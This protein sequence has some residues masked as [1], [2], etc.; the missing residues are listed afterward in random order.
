M[1]VPEQRRLAGALVLVG[2][3]AAC[4]EPPTR[5]LAMAQGAIDAARAAGAADYAS[6]E[7]AAAEQTLDRAQAAVKERDYR[8]ALGHAI[9][10]RTQAQTAARSAADGRVRA[11]LAADERLDA[12][13]VLIEEVETQLAAPEAKRVPPAA[14]RAAEAAVKAALGVLAAT[15][16]AVTAGELPGLDA[17]AAQSAALEQAKGALTPPAPQRPRRRG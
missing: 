7:L 6:G 15:R 4:A 9:E 13:A 11:R 2:L 10:A 5:E 3:L 16:Q 14:R 1:M 8:S 12:L 17:I